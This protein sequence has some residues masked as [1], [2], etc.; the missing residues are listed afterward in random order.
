MYFWEPYTSSQRVHH[1]RGAANKDM[2]MTIVTWSTCCPHIE[3]APFQVNLCDC[4]C[5]TSVWRGQTHTIHG[6]CGGG[7]GCGCRGSCLLTTI[8]GSSNL[9]AAPLRIHLP[10]LCH[11]M[12]EAPPGRKWQLESV[13]A[14]WMTSG[15]SHL[16]TYNMLFVW[17]TGWQLDSIFGCTPAPIARIVRSPSV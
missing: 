13:R 10:S 6:G 11:S 2:R 1:I 7:S 5:H 17:E 3:L 8:L 14:W 9:E 12:F 16:R 15:T 4:V